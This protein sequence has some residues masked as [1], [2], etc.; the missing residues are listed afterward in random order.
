M[1]LNTDNKISLFNAIVGFLGVIVAFL[2]VVF[3]SISSKTV[4]NSKEI[5][6]FKTLVSNLN[7]SPQNSQSQENLNPQNYQNSQ[8]QKNLNSQNYQNSSQSQENLN[9]QNYQNSSQSQEN[10]NSQNY[11]NSQ[12][13]E[14]PNSQNYQNSSQSQENPN[15]QNY[16]NSSQSQENLNSQNYQNSQSQENP[17]SQS[18]Q[19]SQSQENPNSQ[20]YPNQTI[21]PQN[22]IEYCNQ[23]II[24]YMDLVRKN[25]ND[26]NTLNKLSIAYYNRGQVYGILSAD[27]AINDYTD[28]IKINSN[29]IEPYK[30][31]APLYEYKGRRSDSLN[32]YDK[33]CS[34]GDSASCLK[35]KDTR[36]NDMFW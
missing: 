10:L 8:S 36:N 32:D 25:P 22:K 35:V 29:F 24:K 15:S 7:K 9:S 4:E 16:Q 30:E 11:Q 18:Y 28:A 34:L 31:R 1:G 20:S 26:R 3:S 14:N 13:Q 12:S 17:N 6:Q 2:S 23:D 33:A 5:E 19:N 21:I 27:N